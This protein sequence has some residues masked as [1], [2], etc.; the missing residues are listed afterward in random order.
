MITGYQ[1]REQAWANK[2]LLLPLLVVTREVRTWTKATL[3]MAR[4]ALPRPGSQGI[5]LSHR[6]GWMARW[7]R[8]PLSHRSRPVLARPSAPT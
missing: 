8:A 2:Q 5:R 1:A 3:R 4:F 6:A 7:G